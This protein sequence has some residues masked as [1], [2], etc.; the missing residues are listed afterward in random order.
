MHFKNTCS[1]IY[2][3]VI[4]VKT[5]TKSK[6]MEKKKINFSDIKGMLS[7]DQMKSIKGGSIGDPSCAHP[8]KN[9]SYTD[10]YGHVQTSGVCGSYES[11][12]ACFSTINPGFMYFNGTCTH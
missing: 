2:Q 8:A 6:K 4:L 12:C 1:P 10:G 9:C 3:G 11:N 5:I 7:K